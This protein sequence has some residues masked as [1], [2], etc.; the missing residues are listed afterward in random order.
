MRMWDRRLAVLRMLL[1]AGTLLTGVAFAHWSEPLLLEGSV[2]T[3]LLDWRFTAVGHLDPGPPD[4]V[5]D[6]HCRDNFEGPEPYYWQG[7][8]DVGYTTAVITADPH[9]IEVTLNN[10]YPSY[11]NSISVYAKNTGT[12]P[13]II[14]EAIIDGHVVM[15]FDTKVRLDLNG[16]GKDDL[17]IWWKAN[18]FGVQLEPGKDGPQT[19]FWV[20]VLQDAPKGG[21]LHFTI[22]LV[23]VQWNYSEHPPAPRPTIGLS[24][25]IL[26]FSAVLGGPDPLPQVFTVSNL[27]P[28]ESTLN[29]TATDDAAW[30]SLFPTSG[31]LPGG[32]SEPMTANVSISGLGV[33]TYYATVTVS[34]PNATNDPQTAAVVL[35][36][37][38][39]SLIAE[40]LKVNGGLDTSGGY[41]C[42]NQWCGNPHPITSFDLGKLENSDDVRYQSYGVW[43]EDYSDNEY[44]DLEFENIPCG[45]TV[46]SVT[47]KFEWQRTNNQVD[48]ARLRIWN[49]S[50]WSSYHYLSLS[51][52][53]NDTLV[54]LNLKGL[55]GIDTC[56]EVNNLKIRFQASSLQFT[57]AYTKHDWV[58]VQVTYTV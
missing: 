5:R 47:L 6:Y 43:S 25:P 52:P 42:G 2:A 56:F 28:A 38:A 19:S 11:F 51:A 54:T 17:E 53:N 30:L 29:W 3:G 33:G 4:S 35:V 41:W 18:I 10:V 15:D 7:D 44:L 50:S 24:P 31:S 58:Q 23:A 39:P 32:A 37:S 57:N 12:I 16:D 20:H 1:L 8:K 46:N 48:N 45:A 49:G 27:G 55:Y 36:I 14:E 26:T 9:V 13:L 40:N 22:E 21:S 34:D